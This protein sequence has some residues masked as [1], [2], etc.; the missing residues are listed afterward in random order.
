MRIEGEK[1]IKPNKIIGGGAHEKQEMSYE[2]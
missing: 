1:K 2:N